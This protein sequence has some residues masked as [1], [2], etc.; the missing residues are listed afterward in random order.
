MGERLSEKEL[1]AFASG[2]YAPHSEA[3]AQECLESRKTIA[4]LEGTVTRLQNLIDRDSHL[5][6]ERTAEINRLTEENHSISEGI[7][8]LQ[9]A[10]A[11]LTAG[12]VADRP[13]QVAPSW[14]REP[15]GPGLWI[16]AVGGKPRRLVTVLTLDQP[17]P[18][19]SKWFGPIPEV[20]Q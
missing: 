8:Q 20:P 12:V 15:T 1:E 3:M 17:W 18:S 4:N 2:H 16:E 7:K 19:C 14:H 11:M 9:E 13:V 10:N 6:R 5:L